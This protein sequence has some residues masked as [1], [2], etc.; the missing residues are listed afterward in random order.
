M[1]VF[2][3]LDAYRSI[4]IACWGVE[5]KQEKPAVLTCSATSTAWLVRLGSLVCILD[6]EHCSRESNHALRSMS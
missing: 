6:C 3:K 2:K 5:P 4:G 1:Y